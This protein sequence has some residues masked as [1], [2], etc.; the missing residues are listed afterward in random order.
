MMHRLNSLIHISTGQIM[1]VCIRY[2]RYPVAACLDD[3]ASYVRFNH[4]ILTDV[5]IIILTTPLNYHECHH[6]SKLVT[7]QTMLSL[8]YICLN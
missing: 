4:Y 3:V 2:E 8:R 1:H 6:S 7:I 5:L